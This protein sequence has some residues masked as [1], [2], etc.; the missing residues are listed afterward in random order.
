MTKGIVLIM[1]RCI[2]I[3]SHRIYRYGYTDNGVCILVDL[4]YPWIPKDFSYDM[5]LCIPNFFDNN[6]AL[7]GFIFRYEY[8]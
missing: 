5:I 7:S 1:R 8:K 2:R 4:A 3:F 6:S